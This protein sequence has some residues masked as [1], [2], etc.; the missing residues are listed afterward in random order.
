MNFSLGSI[1]VRIVP[2]PVKKTVVTVIQQGKRIAPT[3]QGTGKTAVAIARALAKRNVLFAMARGRIDLAN[4]VFH[5]IT[6]IFKT[7]NS[8]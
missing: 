3:V 5:Y 8:I 6:Q 2:V 1:V 7:V 4:M